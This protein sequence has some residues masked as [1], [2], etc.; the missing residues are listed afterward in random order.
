VQRLAA[1]S[2][3]RVAI[4]VA[5]SGDNSTRDRIVIASIAGGLILLFAVGLAVRLLLRRRG[6][7]ESV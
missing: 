2:G 7:R 4:P 1:Q 5:S 6:Q 3:V